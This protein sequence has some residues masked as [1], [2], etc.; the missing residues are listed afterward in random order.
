MKKKYFWL[1]CVILL[2]SLGWTAC[3]EL[4]AKVMDAVTPGKMT[5]H[6]ATD[7]ERVVVNAH[8]IKERFKTPAGYERPG[9]SE[10][11]FGYYLENLP[12][13]ADGAEALY[14]DGSVKPNHNVYTAVIDLPI[15]KKNLHQCADAVM[16]LRA[17]YLYLNKRFDEIRFNFVSDGK[18]RYY[19]DYVKGDTS[20]AAFWKYLEY[21]FNYA[22]TAS[23]HDELKKIAEIHDIE[24]GDVL[25][26]KKSPYG[27]AVMIVDI[28]INEKGEKICLLAQSYMPA[29]ELQILV[30]PKDAVLSPWYRLNSGTIETPEWTFKSSHLRRFE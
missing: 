30:N 21:V 25:V 6:P 7:P 15:G 16:R 17:E 28:A 27:H 14:Y 1:S 24:I 26:E 23:L 9:F 5:V 2:G 20:Y 29:Q 10:T 8:T 18:P 11:S 3:K 4:P 22:N 19:K 13:K 12:L